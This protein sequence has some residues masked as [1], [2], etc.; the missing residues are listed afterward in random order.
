MAYWKNYSFDF[1]WQSNVILRDIIEILFLSILVNQST[2]TL[3]KQQINISMSEFCFKKKERRK[4][5]N[6]KNLDLGKR[7][8]LTTSK[9]LRSKI[10]PKTQQG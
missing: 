10:L 6:N 2:P 8:T 5:H 3:T 9:G 1:C 4:R 7:M